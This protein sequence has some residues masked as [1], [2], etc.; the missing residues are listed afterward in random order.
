MPW[1]SSPRPQS[2]FGWADGLDDTAHL[3]ILEVNIAWMGGRDV[4]RSCM[5]PTTI[6][7]YSGKQGYMLSD[8]RR[9]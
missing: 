9:E 4:D 1:K 7:S 2:I 3:V 8:N 5:S 6:S